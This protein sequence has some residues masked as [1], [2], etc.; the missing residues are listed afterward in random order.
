MSPIIILR[1]IFYLEGSQQLLRTC[2]F[3]NFEYEID[4]I[5]FDFEEINNN[6]SLIVYVAINLQLRH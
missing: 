3:G 2:N 6:I 1:S 5:L 4:Q